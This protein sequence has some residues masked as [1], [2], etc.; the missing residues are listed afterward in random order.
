[1]ELK[2]LNEVVQVTNPKERTHNKG[3]A[4]DENRKNTINCG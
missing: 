1:V 2:K 4:E 3:V